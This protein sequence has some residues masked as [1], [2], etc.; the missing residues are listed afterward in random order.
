MVLV[1]ILLLAL[2]QP[3]IAE[4]TPDV[5]AAHCIA[6]ER[7]LPNPRA[8]YSPSDW[9]ALERG[10]IL[11][12]KEDELSTRG[13]EAAHDSSAS[14]LIRHAPQ[15]VWAVLTDFEAWPKFM[16]HITRTRVTRKDGSRTWV[17]QNYRVVF[18]GMQHTTVY[19]LEPRFGELSWS[20]DLTE[21]HDIKSSEGH[22]QLI[23]ANKGNE[24]L[25]RYAA[26][27][28][29]GRSVPDSIEGMLK[30]RSLA[31][32]IANLRREVNRRYGNGAVAD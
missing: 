13:S 16:P 23:P 32:L 27:M 15:Q 21:K 24:T 28:D 5:G 6:C 26:E 22:W 25:I 14:G 19:T 3:A 20:L 2:P 4:G 17:R 7:S 10:S 1:V 31:K 29:A 9:Q 30:R 12:A 18:F 8:L 11:L